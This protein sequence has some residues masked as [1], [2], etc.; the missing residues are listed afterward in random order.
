MARR[1]VRLTDKEVENAKPADKA[2]RLYDGDGLQ[3]L[4]R[5][6]GTKVWQDLNL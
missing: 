6:S 3:L 5:T 1:V 2:Y 4:V